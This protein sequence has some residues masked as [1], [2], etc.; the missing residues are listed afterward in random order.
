M[1]VDVE[2]DQRLGE[3][4]DVTGEPTLDQR[5]VLPGEDQ[6]ARHGGAGSL[7]TQAAEGRPPPPGAR[8]GNLLRAPAGA[9]GSGRVRG[10]AGAVRAARWRAGRPGALARGRSSADTDTR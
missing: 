7:W 5:R 8:R 9:Q 2:L 1:D 6:D 10:S 4:A 3:L